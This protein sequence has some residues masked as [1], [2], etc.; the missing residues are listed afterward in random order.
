M[1]TR[2][3]VQIQP[4]QADFAQMQEAWREAEELGTMILPETAGPGL[5][6][7]DAAHGEFPDPLAVGF[8]AHRAG[9]RKSLRL[10]LALRRSQ[11]GG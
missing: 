4:Q 6:A 11:H 1:P 5:S 8:T 7:V 10:Q 9:A 2:I 3:G